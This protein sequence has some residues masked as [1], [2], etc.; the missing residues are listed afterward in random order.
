MLGGGEYAATLQTGKHE[1]YTKGMAGCGSDGGAPV[2]WREALRRSQLPWRN[3][4]G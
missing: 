1:T 4:T 2:G 3:R